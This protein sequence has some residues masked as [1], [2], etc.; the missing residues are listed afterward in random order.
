LYVAEWK[1]KKAALTRVT[2][3]DART[4]DPASDA[5]SQETSFQK[6]FRKLLT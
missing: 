1:A 5:I 2:L 4:P 6:S 3:K